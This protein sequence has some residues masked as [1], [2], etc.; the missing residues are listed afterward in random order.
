MLESQFLQNPGQVEIKN[1]VLLSSPKGTYVNLLDYLVEINIYESLFSG[2]VS[3][4]I[5]L[6]DS[7]NLISMM[8]LMGE[9]LLFMNIKTPGMEDK[10][11]IYKTFRI[12]AISDKIYGDDASK[13][14]YH[15][16]FTTT[17]TFNDL[18]NPIYRAFE[19]TPSQIITRIYEDYLQADRNVSLS[20]NLDETKNPLTILDNPTNK[21]KFVSPGWTPIQCIN[22]I[23][24]KSVPQNKTSANVLF[25][26]TT[27]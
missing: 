27:K 1:I 19:G 11:S 20:K 18:N 16:N 6:A 21:I 4:T 13:L 23:A 8:P 10:F 2:S 14:I 15:L 5:T 12:Y 3:G 24:S 26:E 22:W 7:T 25:W 17:E 9:E